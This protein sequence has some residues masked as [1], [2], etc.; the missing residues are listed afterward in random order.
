MVFLP[1]VGVKTIA[2]LSYDIHRIADDNKIINRDE[3]KEYHFF[4][5]FLGCH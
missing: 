1:L 5:T 3:Y 2:G 4:L